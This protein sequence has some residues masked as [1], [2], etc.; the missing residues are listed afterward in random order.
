MKLL[1]GFVPT[2]ALAISTLFV[3]LRVLHMNVY[4]SAI[5]A[6]VIG[7]LAIWL[8]SKVVKSWRQKKREVK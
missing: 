3:C 2:F 7:N 1:V 8:G 4:Y 6:G 5:L